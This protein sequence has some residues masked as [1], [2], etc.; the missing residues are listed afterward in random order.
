MFYTLWFLHTQR[1]SHLSP[2]TSHCVCV[3]AIRE[4]AR[5][6]VRG[7]CWLVDRYVRWRAARDPISQLLV[8]AAA[9]VSAGWA[10]RGEGGGAC[11]CRSLTRSKRHHLWPPTYITIDNERPATAYDVTMRGYNIF[12]NKLLT[13][14]TRCVLYEVAQN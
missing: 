12:Q 14:V 7:P 9:R 8:S 10:A 5:P 11:Q 2:S 6:N 3:T 1:H 4:G 13:R